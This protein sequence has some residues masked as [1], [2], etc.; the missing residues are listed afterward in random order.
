MFAPAFILNE[1]LISF[2]RNDGNPGLAMTAMLTG[3]ISNIILDYIFIF[4]LQWGMYGAVIATS[5]APV[6]SMVVLMGH[7]ISGNQEFFLKKTRFSS[8]MVLDVSKLGIPSLI[9]E[10]AAGIVMIIFNMLILGIE[11]NVGVAA[12]GV[13]A[14]LVLVFSAVYTGI[15]QGVQPL[16]SNGYGKNDMVKVKAMYRHA[17]FTV[18]LVSVV[19]YALCFIY[20][21]SITSVFFCYRKSNAGSEYFF[22]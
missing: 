8:K 20:A 3:S 18:S 5:M 21:D 4:P 15:A 7:K 19:I 13:I 10:V 22:T 1:V 12:Y 11:G 16:I 9:T 14:N 17:I 6:I 2:V